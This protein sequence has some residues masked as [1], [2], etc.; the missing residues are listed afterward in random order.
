MTLKCALVALITLIPAA[1]SRAQPP[2]REETPVEEPDDEDARNLPSIDKMELPSFERLMKG[3]AVDWIVM[4]N[5]KVIEV[6]PVFP[7]PGAKE[8]IED[9]A[10]KAMRKAG[11]PPESDETKQKRLALSYLPVT[12]LEG[13]ERDYKLHVRFI[14]YIV[15]YEEMMLKRIDQLLEDRKVRQAYE[16]ISALED[17]QDA[18]P[19]VAARKDRVLFVEAAVRLDE[20]QPQ[21]ALALLEALLEKNPRYPGLESQFGTVVEALISGAMGERDPRG[22]RYFLRRLARRF[23]NHKVVKDWTARLMQRTRDLLVSATTAERRGEAEAALDLAEEAARTWPDLPEVLPVYNRLA[24]RYQRLR[25]GVVDL[26]GN[27]DEA[28]PVVL[29][30]AETRL[31]QLTSTPLFEPARMENKSVRYDSKFFM[32]WDP[33][34]LGHS[35]L[36]KLRPW[37][38]AGDSQPFLTAASLAEA[39]A[40]RLNRYSASHDARFAAAVE[41]L[42]V[43]S[44]YELAVRFQQVPLRPEALFAFSLP[45]ADGAEDQGAD[46][47]STT[48]GGEPSPPSATWP[49]V[50]HSVDDRR[51][52]YRR[53]VAENSVA[54][55]DRHVAE[56]IEVRY[57]THEKAIQGLLRGE[58][59]ILPRV[60]VSSYRL[61][62]G[63]AEFFAQ[64]YALP[65]THVLQFNPRTRALSART[66]RR[67]L[68]YALDRRQILEDVFL[69]E[70]AG[71]LGRQTSA[72]FATTS[73]AYFR[74]VEPHKYDPALAFS[75]ARTAE[76]ELGGKIPAL[77][78]LSS[79]EPEI[80]TAAQRIVEQW[81]AIGVDVKRQTAT[82]A[83]LPEAG[84]DDWDIVYRTATLAE[85]LTE[86]WQYL[87][88]DN[89]T[90]AGALAHLPTWLR[91][92]LL[93]LDRVGDW[94]TAKEMLN[95]LHRQFWAEV[96]LI[97]LW[98]IDNVMVYRKHV[99]GVPDRPVEP[100][101]RVERWK[102]EP[103]FTRE[104]PT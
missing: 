2:D 5:K 8:D 98:E 49:F 48:A 20:H 22:A 91:Q 15:Y 71:G 58:V 57:E 79:A 40:Q 75:L 25:S 3:P 102:V 103:W 62:A 1:L 47:R 92:E 17:R 52:V 70:G 88:L 89:S 33:T 39:L 45:P 59:S 38:V 51:A 83:A 93:D 41:S 18:W 77:K 80:Q 72:P 30:F 35:V 74:K 31:R 95:Y 19:G 101:Q 46:P 10:K 36:F 13:E 61:L 21:H 43:R 90:E 37:R 100:Y 96:H 54:S 56:V 53:S 86:L 82:V 85:P 60:P 6:E 28:A 32:E 68:V 81:R 4:H 65:A 34:E 16:L 12:L 104:P 7:R 55:G 76:K 87:A 14:N 44:P 99:R 66:L 63:R 26:P 84:A 11:D 24:N 78:L 9:K 94:N 73:Y 69:R 50:L 67:A 42:E 97:P 27:A 23:Q 64:Q 29:A